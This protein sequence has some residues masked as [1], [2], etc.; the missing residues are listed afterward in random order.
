[1]IKKERKVDIAIF[2]PSLEGGGAERIMVILANGFAQRGLAVDLVL[3][4]AIGPY[5]TEVDPAVRVVDLV[6][7]RVILCLP[8]LV[9]YLRIHRPGAMLSALSHAN[10]VAIMARLCARVDTRLVVSEHITYSVQIQYAKTLRARMMTPL[11]RYLYP[12]ADA[13]IA[14]SQG[15]A[16]DLAE[17]LGLP[18][19]SITVAYNPVV[20][21]TLFEQANEALI[22]P[23]LQPGQPPVV[24]GVGRLSPQ[25]DFSLLIRAIAKVK[26]TVPCR[27]IILGEGA[28]R[29]DLQALIDQLGLSDSV[30]LQ[31][32][33]DNP[34]AWMSRVSLFVLS[35]K[36]EGLPTV[37][38]ESMACGTA[39][40]STNCPSG[41]MEILE[42]GKWGELV[43]V[44]N[45]EA[46]A[47]A[48]KR[49]LQSKTTPDVKVRAKDFGLD[50]SLAVYM[51]TLQL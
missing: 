29:L 31:G 24:L 8:A 21:Q 26:E 5:L 30:V 41:P 45:V 49:T 43:P 14:V 32:F 40:I 1:M 2:I 6:Q 42:G 13:V 23:W 51:K 25:K 47:N 22:H 50:Q 35:S 17:V 44:G 4:R 7:P 27:L 36:Y 34:F 33:V 46:M 11:M 12:R 9:R 28:L 37:L 39:V 19:E 18:L 38:I 10:V 3:A 20:T 16:E 48:I 15:V